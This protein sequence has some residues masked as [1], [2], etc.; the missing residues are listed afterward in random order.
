MRD[1]PRVDKR[2]IRAF[3]RDRA[4]GSSLAVHK[5][6]DPW[7][8]LALTQVA[9]VLD[10]AKLVETGVPV[11]HAHAPALRQQ[12][13]DVGPAPDGRKYLDGHGTSWN[14]VLIRLCVGSPL[15]LAT[16][17]A[18]TSAADYAAP[19]RVAQSAIGGGSGLN[20]RWVTPRSRCRTLVLANEQAL[21]MHVFNVAALGA[22]RR[23]CEGAD[24][25]T[26]ITAKA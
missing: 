15:S 11:R 26:R 17:M 7:T 6:E 12:R 21:T 13:R 14:L 3:R 5:R 20:A 16:P 18:A 8:G 4:P 23:I 19:L 24:V 2:T 25:G 22:M 9:H 10:T 1:G